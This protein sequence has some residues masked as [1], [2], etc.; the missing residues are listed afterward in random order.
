MKTLLQ[1]AAGALLLGATGLAV[2]YVGGG[3]EMALE[4]AA[5]FGLAFLPALATL[6]WVLCGQRFASEMMLLACLGGTG[7]RMAMGLGGG[8]LLTNAWPDLFGAALWGW[9][10]VFYLALLGLEMTLIVRRQA[11]QTSPPPAS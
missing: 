10:V 11:A 1:F 3:A 6:A 7:V 8:L 2:G 9:L 4:A 5:A